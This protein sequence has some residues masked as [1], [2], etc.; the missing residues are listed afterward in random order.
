M[1]IILHYGCASTVLSYYVDIFFYDENK[2][3]KQH[4]LYFFISFLL[5]LD[6]LCQFINII[7]SD[8]NLLIDEMN[9]I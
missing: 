6:F 2:K 1:L 3:S 7:A 8:D 4:I 5:L 9:I